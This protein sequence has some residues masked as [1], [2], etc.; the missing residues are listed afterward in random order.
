MRSRNK[1]LFH[2]W[3][4]FCFSPLFPPKG[5]PII[6]AELVS[7]L[8]KHVFYFTNVCHSPELSADVPAAGQA[9]PLKWEKLLL[10]HNML[11]F[12]PKLSLSSLICWQWIMLRLGDAQNSKM[13]FRIVFSSGLMSNQPRPIKSV[14]LLG[15][16]PFLFPHAWSTEAAFKL[17]SCLNPLLIRV[18]N[19]YYM[20]IW[21]R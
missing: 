17:P 16:F 19:R 10:I 6:R 15:V 18:C 5:P 8:K 11:H 21:L 4:H 3:S 2:H 12:L 1:C 13:T 9:F 20:F 14:S 7:R